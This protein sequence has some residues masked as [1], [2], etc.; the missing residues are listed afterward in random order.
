MPT[1]ID[2]TC[3]EP[4]NISLLVSVAAAVPVVDME[5]TSDPRVT[6]T[7][8]GLATTAL[9]ELPEKAK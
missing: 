3:P 9:L 5:L 4:W 7:S 1:L 8:W 2:F 6:V